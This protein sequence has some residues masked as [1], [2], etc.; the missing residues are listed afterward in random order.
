MASYGPKAALATA[1][2]IILHV[3]DDV[4][5]IVSAAPAGAA[6]YF[7]AGVYRGVSLAPKDGQTFI[8]AEG[9][10]LNGSA[11]LTGWSQ[12]GNLWVIGGQTQQ[13]PIFT[14]GGDPGFQ[15]AGYPDTVFFDNAPLKPVD[16]L[17][18]VVP[19]TF[20]FDYATDRIYIADSPTG[21]TVEAGKLGAAF[22]GSATNVTVQNFVIEKYD[23]QIQEGA[24]CGGQSWTIQD[25]EVRLNYAAG[26]TVHGG[27]Q[28]IGNY[29][30]D[31]G[32]MGLGGSGN[33]I[34]VQ[35]NEIASNGFWSGISPYYEAGGFKFSNTDNLVV[36]GNYS[37]DNNGPGMWTDINNIHTIYEDNLVVHN[38]LSGI[39]HEI[40]YDAI[41]RNN[42]LIGNAYGDSR[43]W[44]F[45]AEI[46]IQNSQNVQVYGN[47]VDMTGGNNGI[48]LIQQDR[49]SGTYGPWVT[50]G[51]QIHDNI[52]VDRDGFLISGG[53]QH[54]VI[55]GFADYNPSGM[56][57]GGN[58][59][60]S[61]QYF[62]SDGLG[63]FQWGWFDTFA[64]FQTAAHET[65][66]ISLS[67]FDTSG[68]L[69]QATGGTGPAT[70]VP[71]VTAATASDTGASNTDGITSVAT[72]T[73]T[74]D[75]YATVEF[76][77]DG[78]TITATATADATGNWAV[79]LTGLPDGEHT[80]LA[81]QTNAAGTGTASLTFLLDTTAP[82][83]TSNLAVD[84]GTSTTD[85][86]TSNAA[87]AGTGAPETIVNFTVDSAAVAA[88]TTADASGSW[89]F[90]PTGLADGQHTIVAT[91][92]DLAGNSGSNSA[93][94]TLDTTPPTV[95][96]RLL[97]AGTTSS[98]GAV[99]GTAPPASLVSFAIDGNSVAGTAA[100]D[101]SGNWTYTPSR[102]VAG[103]HTVIASTTDVAGNAG[104][105]SLT[106]TIVAAVSPLPVVTAQL[107]SDNGA[108]STDSI[109]S[110][111][112]LTGTADPNAV[113]HFM[114]DDTP[115]AAT[116]TA[117]A[118][119][120][121][122]FTP[123]GLSDD[124]HTGV[125]SVTNAAGQTGAA[126]LAF[127]FDAHQ[128]L[129]MFTSAADAKGN[130]VTLTGTT[131]EAGDTVTIYDGNIKV[132]SLITAADGT[133]CFTTK[134]IGGAHT[135]AADATGPTGTGHGLGKALFGS[136]GADALT[137]SSSNDVIV[138][139]DGNDLIT[140]GPGADRLTGG[141]GNDTFTFT[142][143]ADSTAAAA[144]VITDFRHGADKIDFT[145]IAG[146]NV[147][148]GTSTFQGYMTGTGNLT[149]NA[150]SVAVMEVGGNTQV[151][152]NT[153]DTAE[154]VTA[155]DTHAADMK[156]ILFGVNLGVTASDFHHA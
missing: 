52:V 53:D 73:G 19:G 27:S 124:F 134:A 142:A 59:W 2:A 40:S 1:G 145:A 32:E 85:R 12:S 23:P 38:T 65:G 4:S 117:S 48:I 149:L 151:L 56:L 152:V 18:K 143:R 7:E 71:V 51:N 10:I 154:R 101:A 77:V 139:N 74:G 127:T 94:F 82:R 121:W 103:T 15:R 114:I 14:E 64:D 66:T 11:V 72:V 144:D 61:N 105:A 84:T 96:E 25:N 140:G 97:G 13:G 126:T 137:G 91:Q 78:T 22:Y 123:T 57:N 88:T 70:V 44:A 95:T 36:R 146:I 79:S 109:T 30:H 37:H 34:L 92:T 46:T 129:P 93:T 5:A 111:A 49:G 60:S 104:S 6:F 62:M 9:A 83:V 125:A 118:S 87:L 42:T 47:H 141:S 50:T 45:G 131:G 122:K 76:T 150:H 98:T 75:A 113:V 33:N 3:G 147:S 54:G 153:S 132:G 156:I 20:Y 80:I 29:V 99:A 26:I 102:L 135:F 8:G 90:S 17:A 41:I 120:A 86:I 136:S 63:R 81:S 16:A 112:A 133:F 35:G 128:P 108:S 43:G 39:Q 116:A 106:L 119:G 115:I 28:I 55:G 69:T 110:N 89:R 100:A 31:N 130:K 24:I 148:N 107:A 67:G 21:H 58:T 155:T 138:G 68:W